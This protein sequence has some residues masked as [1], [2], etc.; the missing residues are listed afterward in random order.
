[1]VTPRLENTV[2]YIKGEL[3]ELEREEFFRLKKVQAK[4]KKDITAAE[5][6]AKA[7]QAKRKKKK[8][9]LETIEGE[10]NN[11]GPASRDDGAV[12]GIVANG[13]VAIGNGGSNLI[14]GEHDEDILF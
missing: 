14:D 5:N 1:V 10:N 6:D 3:D 7:V 12:D 8:E 13:G 4:K 2:Q 9:E 11:E